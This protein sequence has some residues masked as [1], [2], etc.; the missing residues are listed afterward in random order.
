MTV[1]RARDSLLPRAL[2][3][4]VPGAVVRG[5]ERRAGR[6]RL[7]LTVDDGPD[8]EGTPR[9][10]DA[11]ARH[12]ARA[13]FFLSGPAAARHPALVRQIVEAGHRV[14]NHG[15]DHVSAWRAAPARVR[16]GF[17]RAERVL[18][19]VA[20]GAVRDVRPPYGRVTPGLV[21]WCRADRKP[22]SG[23]GRRL[24]LWDLM[25]GDFLARSPEA[26][27]AETVALARPGGVAVFHD[28]APAERAAA[29]LD[30]ALPRLAAA[31]WQFPALPP[32]P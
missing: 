12:D 20:S 5:P 6:P 21:R 13:V 24:V 17:E 18:E 19:D 8:P 29:A 25:P 31:G 9:W 7:Y 32:A 14:G 16:A 26:L 2:G 11:L 10:L 27:A 3:P 15:W 23:A 22:A 1:Q 30:L 28:G 4:L